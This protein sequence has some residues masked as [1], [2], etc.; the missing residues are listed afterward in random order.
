[1]KYDK[2]LAQQLQKSY[3]KLWTDDGWVVIT[4][5]KN[6]L[7]GP[8]HAKKCLQANVDRENS[9]QPAHLCSLI[10]AFIVC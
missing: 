5:A 7:T 8:C 1:M 2:N 10:R 4:I 9:D 3:L 6:T